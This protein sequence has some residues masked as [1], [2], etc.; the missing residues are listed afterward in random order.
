[1]SE[2]GT[3]VIFMPNQEKPRNMAAEVAIE[4]VGEYSTN[5]TESQS[6]LGMHPLDNQLAFRATAWSGLLF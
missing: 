5:M 3:H 1:M 6:S 4:S 2:Q